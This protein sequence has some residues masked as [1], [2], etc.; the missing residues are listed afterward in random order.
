[1][2]VQGHQVLPAAQVE[3]ALVLVHV[4]DAVV[5]GVE[6]EGEGTDCS[7]VQQLCGGERRIDAQICIDT[8][9]DTTLV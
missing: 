7:G 6:G 2:H 3:T 9:R 1:M 8:H 4:Q 5:T